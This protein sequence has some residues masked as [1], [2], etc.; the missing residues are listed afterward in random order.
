[1]I[2]L[3]SP[4][5][6]IK[7]SHHYAAAR[8]ARAMQQQQHGSQAGLNR[9]GLSF[10]RWVPWSRNPELERRKVVGS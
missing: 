1:M 2:H 9:M 5:P 7:T 8:E 6:D 10:N 3:N 4:E